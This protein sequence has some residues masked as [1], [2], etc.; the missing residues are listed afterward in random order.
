MYTHPDFTR[1][2]VGRLVLALCEAAAGREGFTRVELAATM[3]GVPLYRACGYADIEAFDPEVDD[4]YDSRLKVLSEQIKH[5][6]KE[7]EQPGGMFAKARAADMDLKALGQTMQIRK[8]ELMGEETTLR[9][10]RRFVEVSLGAD[11]V[12]EP[13]A[14][15][16]PGRPADRG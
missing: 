1:R 3:A 2:G 9:P 7:E 14:S 15:G 10:I 6:V 13:G 11:A 8:Q 5:H 12:F 4:F 16:Q